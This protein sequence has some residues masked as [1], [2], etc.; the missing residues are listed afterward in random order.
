M[1]VRRAGTTVESVT[2]V[3]GG[4]LRSSRGAGPGSWIWIA[5]GTIRHFALALLV[6]LPAPGAAFDEALPGYEYQFPRDHFAHPDF[7]AEWWYYTG[8]LSTTQGRPFG[9][10]LTFFRVAVE[11]VEVRQTNWDPDQVYLAHFVIA[12]IQSGRLHR[13]ERVNRDGPGLAG[14]SETDAAIWNGNW[15]ARF[16]AGDPL[17]PVQHLHAQGEATQLDLELRPAKPVVVHGED[18]ISRKSAGE[19]RASHYTSFTRLATSGRIT[20]EGEEFEVAGLAWMDHEFF[21]S[22]LSSDLVGW[23]WMSVQLDDGSDLMIYSL[24]TAE[25]SQGAFSGGTFVGADG[26]QI[27]LESKD[28]RLRPGRT[29]RSHE[30]GAEYPVEWRVE[31]PSIGLT[32]EVEPLL[33]SQEI[34]S[35]FNLTPVYWEGAVTYRGMRDGSRVGGKGYLEMT[36]YDKPVTLIR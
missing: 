8:N 34:V 36:G 17:R 5:G 7:A 35:E 4:D 20:V 13:F 29:W 24:R 22:G 16:G 27:R 21:S 33:D 31:V 25:G 12:D 9:F 1:R 28:F 30:T 32:L 6:A 11:G 15:S 2:R 23:D 10:E 19:G 26:R 3:A 18:G 14:A